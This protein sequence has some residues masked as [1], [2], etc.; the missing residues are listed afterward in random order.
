MLQLLA[1]STPPHKM[2]KFQSSLFLC[3]LAI[4]LACFTPSESAGFSLKLIPRFSSV[5][6]KP[7]PTRKNPKNGRDLPCMQGLTILFPEIPLLWIPK[8]S[9]QLPVHEA[10]AFYSAELSL[11]T[12]QI[13]QYLLID[14]SS[15]L[16]WTQCLPCINCFNQILSLYNST[17]SATYQKIPCTNPR[18]RKLHIY[19]YIYIYIFGG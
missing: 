12:P 5:P 13:F 17:D 3:L 8:T 18:C 16:I 1:G 14:S 7:Q 9:I 11:G 19:I 10:N 4:S 15:S 2:A 6:W